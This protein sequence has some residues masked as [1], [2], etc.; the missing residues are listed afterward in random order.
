MSRV[1]RVLAVFAWLVSCSAFAFPTPASQAFLDVSP[2]VSLPG[3]DTV[4]WIFDETESGV[5][6]FGPGSNIM[7]IRTGNLIRITAD[8]GYVADATSPQGPFSVDLGTLLPGRYTVDYASSSAAVHMAALSF[9][10]SDSV[11]VTAIEYYNAQRDHYFLTAY[12]EEITKLALVS[13]LLK[14]D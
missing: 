12:P 6:T 14:K 8:L 2:S 4:I 5:Q 3:G 10:V 7:V 11:L 1:L 9:S 13:G